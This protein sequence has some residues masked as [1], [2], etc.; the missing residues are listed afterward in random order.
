MLP[1]GYLNQQSMYK[2]IRQFLYT[3]IEEAIDILDTRQKQHIEL[4]MFDVPEPLRFPFYQGYKPYP[5]TAILCR[6]IATPN[7]EIFRV[8]ELCEKYQLNLLIL[9]FQEDKFSSNNACKHALGQMGFFEGFG[10]KGGKKIRYSTIINFN[11]FN[12]RSLRECKTCRGQPFVK[13]HH[14]LLLQELPGLSYKNIYDNSEWF[15]RHRKKADN[16]YREYLKLFLKHT[17]L[18]ETFVLSGS[19]LDFTLKKVLPAFQEIVDN[20]GIKPL[21]VRSDAPD[22]EGDDYWQLYPKHLHEF[23]PFERRKAPRYE[24]PFNNFTPAVIKNKNWV[25]EAK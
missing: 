17:I 5:Y 9:S 11:Q 7:H 20:F 19:E 8:K 10:R 6:H 25:I 22:M 18:F 24:E 23:A 4:P 14:D 1:P 2:A 13:F 3:P 15:I 12:G 16:L 21:I